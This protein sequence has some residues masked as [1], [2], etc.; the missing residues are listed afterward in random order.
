M[1]LTLKSVLLLSSVISKVK[2]KWLKE[3]L[4]WMRSLRIRP[5][6]I[7][8]YSILQCIQFISLW[9]VSGY[10]HPCNSEIYKTGNFLMML[11]HLENQANL[12]DFQV[13]GKISS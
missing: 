7:I 3:N 1:D 8:D 11:F 4:A 13:A 10:V 2:L 5:N 9:K 12:K 6:I